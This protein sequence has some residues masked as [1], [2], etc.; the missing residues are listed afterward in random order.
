MSIMIPNLVLGDWYNQSWDYRQEI[1]ISNT[2]GDLTNYQV[3]IDLNSTNVGSNFNWSNNGSDIRFTNS[4]DDEL[5]FWIESWS[6]TTNISIIWVNVTSLPNNQNTTIY[7]YYGN[8][9][10]TSESNGTA[11]FEFF[12]DFEV[13]GAGD[14][15]TESQSPDYDS[16]VQAKSPTHSLELKYGSNAW[17]Q[18]HISLTHSN[19]IAI[20][21]WS[22]I[23]YNSLRVELGAQGDGTERFQVMVGQSAGGTDI[24]YYD[25]GFHDT[26]INAVLDT[27]KKVKFYNFD[28]SAHTFTFEYNGN[29][30]N[31]IPMDSLYGTYNN[32]EFRLT[33]KN[34]GAYYDDVRVRKYADPE[35]T[36]SSF[37]GEESG[38]DTTPPTYSDNSTNS[39][40]AGASIEHRLKWEDETSLS[41]YIFSFCNGTWNGSACEFGY[42][43][44]GKVGN[45]LLFKGNS[46]GSD[47]IGTYIDCGNDSTLQPINEITIDTWIRP[48]EKQESSAN[49]GIAS[50][51]QNWSMSSSW[52]W[53]I[54]YGSTPDLTLGFQLNTNVGSGWV[55]LDQNLTDNVW[56]HIVA[57]FNGTDSKIYLNGELKDTHHFGTSNISVN[58]ANKILIG[59]EGWANYF[60]GTIDEFRLYN[61]SLNATEVNWS[62]IKGSAGLISNVS[63]TGLVGYWNLDEGSGTI[64]DDSSPVGT[65]DGTLVNFVLDFTNDSWVEMSGTLNWSNV[66][67]TV[68]S[69]IGDT[70]AWKVYAKDQ[71]NNWN[72]TPLYYYITTSGAND[73]TAP[74]SNHP[75]DASYTQN[76]AQTIGWILQDETSA[77]YYYVKRNGTIQ[78]SSTSW[79]N[80]TN[81]NV[82]VNTSTV[83]NNWNY[84]IYFNDSAGNEGTPDTVFINITSSDTC[85]N[86]DGTGNC[87][88]DCSDDCV[89]SSNIDMNNYNITINQ[90][91]TGNHTITIQANV[92]NIGYVFKSDYDSSNICLLAVKSGSSFG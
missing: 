80:N 81:L 55:K 64:A 4:T 90:S 70:I 85:S 75:S 65:N 27:W 57:T 91:T 15:V 2:A 25:N 42:W 11:T 32:N 20:E 40:I 48:S 54:R 74:T 22:Y 41:G 73:T 51:V 43:T 50:S 34:A 62:Y 52:S 28:W 3:R 13:A 26:N 35:P 59:N 92:T 7:M 45:A 8:S 61:R 30:A 78:N 68:S 89:I 46:T 10:A 23:D 37:G 24:Y 67:K 76:S 44:T 12:D 79:T 18:T 60:N 19:N 21:Y 66:T 39:T 38:E 56:Y 71:V 69:N 49:H 16:T 31:N 58:P 82:W 9:E 47:G 14:W 36:V 1:N 88:W 84:T 72:E 83:G 29:V 63:T 53:Q 5:Y 6:N 86:C 87:Y 17:E 33:I 77:G